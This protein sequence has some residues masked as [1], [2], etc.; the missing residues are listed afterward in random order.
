MSFFKHHSFQSTKSHQFQA[1]FDANNSRVQLL[2]LKCHLPPRHTVQSWWNLDQ[3]FV[4]LLLQPKVQLGAGDCIQNLRLG[5]I[6]HAV[7]RE[8]HPG[9]AG[10]VDIVQ[11]DHVVDGVE[12]GKR[13]VEDV[14]LRFG[15]CEG[16]ARAGRRRGCR[17]REGVQEEQMGGFVVED[18]PLLLQTGGWSF[19]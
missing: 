10:F 17:V 8:R 15:R 5:K 2:A 12:R 11:T 14:V 16:T 9:A 6:V 19:G 3:L 1:Q 13:S 4:L 7:A 18:K